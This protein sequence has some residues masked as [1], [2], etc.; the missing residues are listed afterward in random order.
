MKIVRVCLKQSSNYL[1]GVGL[2]TCCLASKMVDSLF[3]LT[4]LEGKS[5]MKLLLYGSQLVDWMEV[6]N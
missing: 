4:S 1:L 2:I 6:E 5:R 3:I